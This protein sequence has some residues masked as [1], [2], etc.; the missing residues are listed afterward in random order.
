[1]VADPALVAQAREAGVLGADDGIERLRALADRGDAAAQALFA[2]A[3]ETL[4]RAVADLANVLSP[5]LVLISGEG[6]QA[7]PHLA[8]RFGAAFAASLFPP[9]G[10]TRV[11]VD[12]WDDAKWAVGAATLVLRASFAAPLD[13]V[14][15]EVVA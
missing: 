2:A 5:E 13:D 6:T 14:S 8:D 4:G 3:G 7:W 10:G 11:E 1:V 15:M 12:P 9:L